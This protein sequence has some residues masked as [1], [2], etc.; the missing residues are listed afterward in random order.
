MG[1]DVYVALGDTIRD[2]PGVWRLR[3][4]HHPLIDWVFGGAALDCPR[5]IHVARRPAA[6]ARALFRRRRDDPPTSDGAGEKAPAGSRRL[7]AAHPHRATAS[8]RCGQRRRWPMPPRKRARRGSCAN[9]AAWSARTSRS[10]SRQRISRSTCAA[11][12]AP[13][14]TRARRIRGRSASIS[15]TATASL[16]PSG[17]PTD[18]WGDRA[19]GL[20]VPA[21]S[22]RR[23]PHWRFPHA[24]RARQRDLTPASGRPRAADR[25]PDRRNSGPNFPGFRLLEPLAPPHDC[26]KVRD[27]RWFDAAR[28]SPPKA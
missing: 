2:Q 16:F 23:R 22:G 25:T 17:R 4:A 15:W 27:Y 28:D 24:M 8:G 1:G 18:G 5:R 12:F 11:S 21:S 9:S 6:S 26:L 19:L 14:S 7:K 13:R 3:I 20:S 10:P